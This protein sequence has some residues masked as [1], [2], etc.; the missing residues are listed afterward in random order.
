MAAILGSSLCVLLVLLLIPQSPLG[1]T[2]HRHLVE[3][4]LERLAK[5]ERH[6]LINIAII[7]AAAATGGELI[8][9]AGPELFGMW[10]LDL[11]IY[12]DAVLV[13]YALAAVVMARNSLRYTSLRWRRGSR[14]RRLVAARRRRQRVARRRV[15]QSA[16]DDDDGPALPLAA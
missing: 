14:V 11:A 12:F 9:L 8:A 16:N 6:H 15:P 2:L 4:P 7:A 3:R 10:A 1:R 5:F 13:T